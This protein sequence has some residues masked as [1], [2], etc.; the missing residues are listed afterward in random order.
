MAAKKA[1]KVATLPDVGTT[2]GDMIDLVCRG[3]CVC[4]SVGLSVSLSLCVC[5][6]V[7]VCACVCVFVFV[8]AA[9]WMRLGGCLCGGT[10]CVWGVSV[11]LGFGCAGQDRIGVWAFRAGVL[12]LGRLP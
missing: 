3:V 12:W 10:W 6:Y 11:L 4:L 8:C 2:G 1:R 7:C 5:I 9:G